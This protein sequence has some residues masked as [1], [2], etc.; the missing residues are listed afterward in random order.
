M[1]VLA[2]KWSNMQIEKNIKFW[3]LGEYGHVWM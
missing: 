2:M 3:H 1:A